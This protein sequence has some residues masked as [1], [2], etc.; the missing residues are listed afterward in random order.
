M[1]I[2]QRALANGL[3]QGGAALGISCAFPVFGTVID[4]LDWQSA[5]LVS[6]TVTMLVALAWMRYGANYPWQHRGATPAPGRRP[7]LGEPDS[8]PASPVANADA[9]ETGITPPRWPPSI[10][11]DADARPWWTLLANPSLMLLTLSYA[12]INY[13]EYLFFFWMHYY[14]E[15]VLK[16][17][18]SESRVFAAILTLAMAVGMVLGGWLADRLQGMT[19]SR[20][21]AA[22]VPALGLCAGGI[23][24]VLGVLA[25]ETVWIVTLL[26][27]ALAAVGATEA[28]VWTMAVE[29]GRRHGGT[30]AAICNT[31]GNGGGLL[32]P[33]IT[34]FVGG[35]V[36]RQFAVSDQIGWQWAIGLGSGIAVLGAVLWFWITPHDE[37]SSPSAP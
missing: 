16:F 8:L 7:P 21:S 10:S 19:G 29:L 4:W 18:K 12:A 9:A 24:L 11:S 36:S 32:A 2:S 6:G 22:L 20:K 5:F 37:R 3:V 23:L 28:P 26:A 25:Q 1:P 14:F 35:W 33:I 15:D 31:G 17:G 30:A 34:P 13:V 27:L